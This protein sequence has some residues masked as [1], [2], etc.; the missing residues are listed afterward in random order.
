MP[1]AVMEAASPQVVRNPV[2]SACACSDLYERR[3]VVKERWA[4]F[5]AGGIRE[6]K[7]LPIR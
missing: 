4:E 2:G 3:R 5:F 1:P 6:P 7:A